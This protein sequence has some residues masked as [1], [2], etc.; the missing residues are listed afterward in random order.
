[1]GHLQPLPPPKRPFEFVSIDHMGPLVRTGRGNQHVLVAI[2]HL[3]KWV[4]M[5]AVPD[6]SA[7]RTIEFLLHRV[8]LRHGFPRVLLSDRGTA[9]TA[10]RMEKFCEEWGIDHRMAAPEHPQTNGLVERMNRTIGPTL[11]AYVNRSHTNWDE[12]VPFA[13]FAINTAVQETTGFAPFELV[14]GRTAV[15]P[16]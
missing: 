6:T 10:R 1:M 14:H 13:A 5:E 4:E 2:D 11:A 9:F 16:H 7:S 15:L 12:V 8:C 3:T